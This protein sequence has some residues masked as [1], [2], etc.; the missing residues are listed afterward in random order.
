MGPDDAQDF[1]L[2][3]AECRRRLHAFLK[4]R[5]PPPWVLVCEIED[6]VQ[7][8]ASVAWMRRRSA[9]RDSPEAFF[10]WVSRIAANL[11]RNARR[12]SR[13]ARAR[14][15]EVERFDEG[16]AVSARE[17]NSIQAQLSDAEEK[18]LEEAGR[19]LGE[20]LRDEAFPTLREVILEAQSQSSIASR[21]GTSRSAISQRLRAE[22]A[23]LRSMLARLLD[24]EARDRLAEIGERAIL[25]RYL[26]AADDAGGAERE[27]ERERDEI[28][29]A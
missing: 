14:V 24:P 15:G 28:D 7:E 4:R 17:G 6:L 3:F 8:A 2:R 25:S 19:L 16:A 9:P 20:L 13:R 23:R 1:D 10:R 21:H 27:R 11:L 29:R 12:A 18:S 26:P 22:T 5:A